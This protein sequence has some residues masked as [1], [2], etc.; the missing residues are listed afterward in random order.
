YLPGMVRGELFGCFANSEPGVGSDAKNITTRAELH[1]GAYVINGEKHFCTTA[2]EAGIAII[3]ARTSPRTTGH[4]GMTAF[5][6]ELKNTKGIEVFKQPKNA[7]AGSQLCRIICDNVSVD[8]NAILGTKDNGWN[9]CDRTFLHSRIWIG[10]QGAGAALRALDE[11]LNYTVNQR[12]AFN[13][14][15]FDHQYVSFELAKIYIAIRGARLL[16]REAAG[17]ETVDPSHP[18]FPIMA[19]GAKYAGTQAAEDAALRYYRF[20][21][22]LSITEEWNAAQHLLDSLILPIYEGPNE[23]QLQIIANHL[24]RNALR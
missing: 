18:D 22:G 13:K 15:V 19:A 2:S 12:A 6:I 24:K 23:I 9:V 5:L 8:E 11:I 4:P 17:Q 3:F 10:A 14:P 16:A 1:N 20:S 21:G 7:Q